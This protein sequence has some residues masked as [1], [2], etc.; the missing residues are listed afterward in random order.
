MSLRGKQSVLSPPVGAIGG[1]EVSRPLKMTKEE[2]ENAV[3]LVRDGCSYS[4]VGKRFMGLKPNGTETYA[5]EF[6]P[7]LATHLERHA[8]IL[9]PFRGLR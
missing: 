3:G 5:K 8:G 9:I 4:E 1:G 7:S 2:I 6:Q